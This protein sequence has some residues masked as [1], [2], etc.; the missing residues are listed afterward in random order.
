[1]LMSSN[2]R[3]NRVK[4]SILPSPGRIAQWVSM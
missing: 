2:S 1:L 3:W 4:Y